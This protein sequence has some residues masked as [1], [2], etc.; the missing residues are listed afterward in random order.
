MKGCQ[1][2]SSMVPSSPKCSVS[3][4]RGTTLVSEFDG[5]M[6]TWQFTGTIGA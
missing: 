6:K 5:K 3:K 4:R 1:D 2:A